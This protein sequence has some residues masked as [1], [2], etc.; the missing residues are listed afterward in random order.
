MS[1]LGKCPICGL[2]QDLCIC[3]DIAREEQ[4]IRVTI[5][6]RRWGKQYTV[7]KGLDGKSVDLKDL[8][9]KMKVKL[10]CGGTAK[11][12]QIEL[13]GNHMYR[14]KDLLVKLGFSA[15]NIDVI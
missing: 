11:D 4:R 2:D 3:D 10:A 15:D 5:E 7:L 13:Q 12:D 6:R 9:H 1:L 14:V 8:A